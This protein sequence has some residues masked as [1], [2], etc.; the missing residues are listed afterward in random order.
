[1]VPK[2]NRGEYLFA[3]LAK[4]AQYVIVAWLLFVHAITEYLHRL[5]C[6]KFISKH[7]PAWVLQ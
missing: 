4:N 3:E 1:M 2:N 5:P 7:L 6:F